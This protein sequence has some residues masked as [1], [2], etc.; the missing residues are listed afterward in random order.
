MYSL[1]SEQQK[2]LNAEKGAFYI[3]KD[4]RVPSKLKKKVVMMYIHVNN[5]RILRICCAKSIRSTATI[6]VHATFPA[7]SSYQRIF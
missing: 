1:L 4:E 5:Q 6:T 2:A 3:S 7:C